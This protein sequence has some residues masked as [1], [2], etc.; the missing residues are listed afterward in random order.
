M[1]KVKI[2]LNELRA[3]ISE[4]ESR[5]NDV[6]ISIEVEDRRVKLTASDRM[7]NLVEAI[8]YEEGNLGAQFRCT[9]RLMYM[10]DKKRI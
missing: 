5:T 7:E 3:A 1:S 4:I 6:Q 8:L 10:K 9:E 2:D